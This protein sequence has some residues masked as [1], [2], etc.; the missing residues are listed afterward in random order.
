[1]PVVSSLSGPETVV[2]DGLQTL[3][4]KPTSEEAA[5]A[6]AASRERR[7]RDMWRRLADVK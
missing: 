2:V 6:L 5:A 4:T 1:L 7:A 3:A